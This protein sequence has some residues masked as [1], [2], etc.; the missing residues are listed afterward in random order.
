MPN[1]KKDP[2]QPV[3]RRSGRVGG[4][5]IKSPSVFNSYLFYHDNSPKARGRG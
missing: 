1:V 2:P 4:Q 5:G 3:T